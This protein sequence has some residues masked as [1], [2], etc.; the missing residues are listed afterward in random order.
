M[1]SHDVARMRC[2]IEGLSLS[3]AF[4]RHLHN[5]AREQRRQLRV[6]TYSGKMDYN[7]VC[8]CANARN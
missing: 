4:A 3:V 8:F 5:R 2:I 7:R 1:T 6:L